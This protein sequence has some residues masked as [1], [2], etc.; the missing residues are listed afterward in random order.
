MSQGLVDC[1]NLALPFLAGA[2]L[3]LWVRLQSEKD[4]EA[5]HKREIEQLNLEI[6][7][8][9][10]DLLNAKLDAKTDQAR[11]SLRGMVDR[12]AGTTHAADRPGGAAGAASDSE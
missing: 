5:E 12:Q 4:Q 11:D 7:R 1:L 2:G 9:E 10:E 6:L 3:T 8:L